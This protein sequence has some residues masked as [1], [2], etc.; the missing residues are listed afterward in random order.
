M[1]V[2]LKI[3][4]QVIV[5]ETEKLHE[6][7][8]SLCLEYGIRRKI[9]DTYSGEK[10]NVKFDLCRAMAA[11]MQSGKAPAEKTRKARTESDPVLGLAVRNA[12]QDLVAVFK[13][14]SGK[15]KLEDMAAH[16]K[17]APYFEDKGGKLVWN[18]EAVIGWVGKQKE[19]GK[20][21]YMAEAESTLNNAEEIDI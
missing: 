17:I 2:E 13:R 7:W 6:D 10:G 11:D 21:D 4:G 20:R 3:N 8:V 19:A 9:N 16:E 12:K 18:D 14:V 15:V 1:Q 5:I